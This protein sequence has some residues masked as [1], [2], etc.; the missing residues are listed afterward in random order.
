MMKKI[1]DLIQDE[2]LRIKLENIIRKVREEFEPGNVGDTLSGFKHFEAVDLNLATLLVETGRVT[3]M[4]DTELFLLGASAYLH[5]L[6]KSSAAGGLIT[7]GEKLMGVLADRPDLYGLDHRGE[8]IP[9]GF[10]SAAHSRRSLDNTDRSRVPEDFATSS[11][12]VI[13]LRKLAAI[14][15]LADS[16]D[17]TAQRASEMM[18]HIHYPEGFIDDEAKGKWTA[19]RAITGWH[20][21]GGKIVLQAH[22][23]SFDEREAVRRAKTLME[24]DLSEVKPTLFA[25]KFPCELELEIEEDTLLKDK[26]VASIHEAAPS[27]GMDYYDESDQRLFMGR[28]KDAERVEGYIAAYPIT[29]LQGNS[30]VGKTSLI[31]ARLVPDLKQSGWERVYLRPFGDFSSML[32]TIKRSY[33]VDAA[34]LA[35]AFRKLDEKLKKK[36]LVVI[37]Q[38]EDVLSWPAELF[39]EF[40]LDLCSI[41][42]LSNPKLLIGV[43][44]D[45]LCDLN[46]KIFKE[47]M[48]SGF[49]TVELGG[50]DRAGAREALK[51]AF[52][53]GKMT[54]HPLELIEEILDDLIELGPFDEIYPPHLQMVVEELFRNADKARNLIL[55]H[56]YRKLGNARGIVA[57]YLVRKLDEFGDD[58]EDAITVL[59]CLVSSRGRKAPQKNVSE[60]ATETGITKTEL[61]ELL[62][63]LVND[64]MIR[65]LAG[66]DYEIIHDH[67]GDHVDKEFVAEQERHIKYLREQLHA[68]ID[69]FERNKALMHGEILAELYHNREKMSVDESA[70]PVLLATWCAH[71]FPVWYWLKNAGNKNIIELTIKMCEHP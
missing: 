7:H 71:N 3:K 58:R 21:R 52:D 69:A 64:R 38:F 16:L 65:K 70:Y 43:R 12:E 44:S 66:T 46:R 54:L 62:S 40:I 15:L 26:A 31:R 36:L 57:A 55:A 63:R 61:E 32:K 34:N 39:P 48:T 9:V 27:K 59:K 28:K 45:A 14:F 5:D 29:V 1:V 22:P 51:T 49:P 67:F 60:I 50:L 2:N 25:L 18:K 23:E 56:T 11:G 6:L 41:H 17:T 20:I 30:G 4:S 42:G 35:E 37:D 53:V 13:D 24:S 10:I 47:V 8:V 19:R 33:G 68:A